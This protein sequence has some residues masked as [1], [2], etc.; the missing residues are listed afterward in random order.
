MPYK[1]DTNYKTK[2]ENREAWTVI[3]VGL[4]MAAIGIGLILLAFFR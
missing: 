4:G 3:L 1:F 2:K